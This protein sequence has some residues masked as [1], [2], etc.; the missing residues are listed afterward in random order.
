MCRCSYICKSMQSMNVGTTRE[1]KHSRGSIFQLQMY[2]LTLQLPLF[3]L[4]PII[5]SQYWS[6]PSLALVHVLAQ[7]WS[8]RI[9]QFSRPCP[10]AIIL[11]LVLDLVLVMAM[12]QPQPLSLPL[13]AILALALDLALAL[14]YNPCL[15]PSQPWSLCQ[16]VS[17]SIASFALSRAPWGIASLSTTADNKG[18]A[19]A[20]RSLSLILLMP[21]EDTGG[22][23]GIKD[24]G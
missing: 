7:P 2:K 16:L 3:Y 23:G 9:T 10:C 13:C 19:P 4:S 17:L 18:L 22:S 15:R 24:A 6:L 12:A 8:L 5:T 21:E 20:A 1:V 11:A 14:V